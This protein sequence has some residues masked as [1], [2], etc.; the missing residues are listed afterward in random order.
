M[1]KNQRCSRIGKEKRLVEVGSVHSEERWY[2]RL[3]CWCSSVSSGKN[4]KS[5]ERSRTVRLHGDPVCQQR[6]VEGAI[7]EVRG[8]QA[9]RQSC[10]RTK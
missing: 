6:R 10:S 5:E 7:S 3:A 8:E 4:R 1:Q 9:N 2:G